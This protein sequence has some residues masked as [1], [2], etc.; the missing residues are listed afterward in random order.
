MIV[1]YMNRPDPTSQ[2]SQTRPNQPG[3][4]EGSRSRKSPGGSAK[5]KYMGLPKA[6]KY[7]VTLLSLTFYGVTQVQTYGCWV[8]G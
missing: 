3:Q 8:G 7:G 6:N 5:E 1:H 2:P 4:A